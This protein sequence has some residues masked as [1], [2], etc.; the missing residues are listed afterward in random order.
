MILKASQRGAAMQLGRHLLNT[1]DNEHVEIAEVRGFLADDVFGAMKEAQGVAAGTRCRQHL[2]SVSLSPPETEAVG[3]DAFTRAID[4]IEE[5]HGLTDHPRI[6]VFH[7]KEGR[8]HAHAVWSRIDV[9]TMTAVPLPFF[10]TKLRE[11]SKGLYLEH[12]WQMP[13]GLM[14][15]KERDPRNFDLAEWQ[16]AKRSG[17]DPRELK[18]IIQDCWAV[19]DSRAAFSQALEARGLHLAKGDRR[20][21][22]AVTYEGE[23]LSIARVI[24]KPAKEIVAKLGKPDNLRSVDGTRAHIATVIAPKLRALIAEAGKHWLTSA[25][26]AALRHDRT[27]VHLHKP[28]I[29]RDN[30]LRPTAI[31]TEN[32]RLRRQPVFARSRA[33]WFAEGRRRSKPRPLLEFGGQA[34]CR[35]IATGTRGTAAWGGVGAS[36]PRVGSRRSGRLLHHHLHL[37]CRQS[38]IGSRRRTAA[39]PLRQSARWSD[40][41]I[42]TPC[43]S[44]RGWGL[45]TSPRAKHRR[46]PWSGGRRPVRAPSR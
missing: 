37:Q 43:F 42:K 1:A 26:A 36:G 38:V 10:K 23:V 18:S 35:P 24:G 3:V 21:H 6:V 4:Q 34:N 12:G 44:R 39:A 14:D 7:E 29:S 20:G 13:R 2:F 46:R 30:A 45:P 22:V 41:D 31:G 16:Q 15:S 28:D 27:L 17:R 32:V 25:F 8:R 5:R 11:I 33:G 9:E 40:S 19:S